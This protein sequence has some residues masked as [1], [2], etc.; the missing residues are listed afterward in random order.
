MTTMQLNNENKTQVE[1][2]YNNG[3]PYKKS[4]RPDI[5]YGEWGK[6]KNIALIKV[7]LSENDLSLVKNKNDIE[8]KSITKINE[9]F[10]FDLD[11]VYLV[12]ESSKYLDDKIKN[13][14][15]LFAFL[16]ENETELFC[17]WGS[18]E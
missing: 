7:K 11:D 9:E 10:W 18:I 14:K 3:L 13:E 17:S 2:N 15:F 4:I 12:F 8:C 1:F 16:N 5:H 6:N